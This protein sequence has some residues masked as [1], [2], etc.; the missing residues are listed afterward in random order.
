MAGTYYSKNSI[1]GVVGNKFIVRSG[2]K[3]EESSP[4]QSKDAKNS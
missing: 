4:T 2:L 1:C 3:V